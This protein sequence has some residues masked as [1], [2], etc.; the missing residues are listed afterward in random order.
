MQQNPHFLALT[1]LGPYQNN[2]LSELT[3]ISKQCDSSIVECKT[4]NLGHESAML[5]HFSGSWGAIAKL[6]AALPTFAQNYDLAVHIKRTTHQEATPSLPYQ[7]QVVAE[8]RVGILHELTAFFHRQAIRLESLDC[9]THVTKNNTQRVSLLGLIAVPVKTH[10]A[11]LREAF[12][13]Y[14]EDRNLDATLDP[15]R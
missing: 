8:N 12:L 10:I 9:E 15:Y 5:F 1:V 11:S 7:I 3:R 13:S 4:T 14:C 6:E 2:L